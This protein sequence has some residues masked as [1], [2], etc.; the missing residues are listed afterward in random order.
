MS[1]KRG[2][3]VI[4]VVSRDGRVLRTMGIMVRCA[5]W[6][7]LNPKYLEYVDNKQFSLRRM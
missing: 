2:G 6:K 7:I 3:K 4:R 1:N 5:E